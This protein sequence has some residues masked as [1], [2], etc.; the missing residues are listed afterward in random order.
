MSGTWQRAPSS[1]A[2]VLTLLGVPTSA[3][4]FAPGQEQAPRALRRAGLVDKLRA[5]GAEVADLGDSEVWRWR[6]D[7]AG[8][9]A[10]NL[11]AVCEIART[12]AGRV[13]DA[14]AEPGGPLLV[15]GGDCTVEIGTVA[16]HLRRDRERRVSSTSTSTRT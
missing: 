8:P 5:A 6:P 2:T 3:G 14:L 16:G 12:T 13:E 1:H 9:R 7:P 15:L 4:A 11:G 10:Q